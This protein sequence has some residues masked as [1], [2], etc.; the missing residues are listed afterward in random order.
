MNQI[1]DDNS[2]GLTEKTFEIKKPNWCEG[3][4]SVHHAETI[5]FIQFE[6][7]SFF[8]ECFG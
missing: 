8:L 3:M 1:Y 2:N 4:N 5:D 6:R 7:I